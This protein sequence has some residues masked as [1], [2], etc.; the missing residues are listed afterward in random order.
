MKIPHN[1]WIAYT[2]QKDE[3]LGIISIPTVSDGIPHSPSIAMIYTD[4]SIELSRRLKTLIIFESLRM[5]L[6]E[7]CGV[8][9]PWFEGKNS[10]CGRASTLWQVY[11]VGRKAAEKE[12][13]QP[14]PWIP[15]ECKLTKTKSIPKVKLPV[16]PYDSNIFL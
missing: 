16:W 8:V 4:D 14:K 7:G 11:E 9:C 13:W 1:Y 10:C 3:P 15:P 2:R 5:Q 12:L 6:A